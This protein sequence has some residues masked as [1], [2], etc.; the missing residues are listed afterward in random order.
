VKYSKEAFMEL[1]HIL[2]KTEDDFNN[3][4]FSLR[5]KKR[6]YFSKDI[7]ELKAGKL[8]EG[9]DIYAET[10]R[11]KANIIFFVIKY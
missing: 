9:T 4:I 6:A 8:I 2:S 7:T 5:G 1:L 11:S 3:K 10:N